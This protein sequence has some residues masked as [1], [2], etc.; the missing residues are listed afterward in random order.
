MKYLKK[1]NESLDNLYEFIELKDFMNYVG[2]NSFKRLVEFSDSDIKTIKKFKGKYSF[3]I[4]THYMN[5]S[6]L[7]NI[8]MFG[9]KSD[10]NLNWFEPGSASLNYINTVVRN[11]IAILKN[12]DDFYLVS[13]G[14]SHIILCD[15][16]DGVVSLFKD[17]IK[18]G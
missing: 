13:I 6:S 4:D 2:G 7:N 8:R 5:P 11:G 1:F 15:T 18:Q 16:I 10:I 9:S 3:S 14:L 17:V 12:D